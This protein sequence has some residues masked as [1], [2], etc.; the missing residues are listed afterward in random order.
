MTE[1]VE[2]LKLDIVK[3]YIDKTKNII[4]IDILTNTYNDTQF[5]QLLEYFKN[6]WLLAK[7]QNNKYN[8]MIDA[9]NIGIYPLHAYGKIKEALVSLENIFKTNLHSSCLIIESELAV[10]I[11]KPI[12]TIY[13]SVRPFTFVNKYEEGIAFFENNKLL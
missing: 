6:L 8:M 1:I 4:H 5:D 2:I 12:L 7:E 3:L 11:F 13:K 9:S 10:N